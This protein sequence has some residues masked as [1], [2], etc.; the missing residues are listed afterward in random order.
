MSNFWNEYST[1]TAGSDAVARWAGAP[2]PGSLWPQAGPTAQSGTQFSN[3]GMQ[4]S[5]AN[6]ARAR[7]V[8]ADPNLPG[9]GMNTGGAFLDARAKGLNPMLMAESRT[10]SP[11]GQFHSRSVSD[12]LQNTPQGGVVAGRQYGP[13]IGSTMSQDERNYLAGQL[14]PHNA[15]LAGSMLGKRAVPQGQ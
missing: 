2:A 8:A 12:I 9:G 7:A 3:T 13:T 6:Q 15:V 1:P 5:L 10:Y 14:G 4:R 11:G